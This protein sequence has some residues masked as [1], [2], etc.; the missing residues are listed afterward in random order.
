MWHE[1]EG[2]QGKKI[3][4]TVENVHWPVAWP[5]HS[6]QTLRSIKL[7]ITFIAIKLELIQEQAAYIYI[8]KER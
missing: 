6:S 8:Y 4:L 7:K 3:C 1:E 5:W 2:A